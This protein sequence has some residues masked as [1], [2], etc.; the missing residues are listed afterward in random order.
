MS[1][2][3]FLFQGLDDPS[4]PTPSGEM[5][6]HAVSRGRTIRRRRHAVTLVA[7][8]GVLAAGVLA[9]GVLAA[10]A[11]NAQ[12]GI[13]GQHDNLVP[14]NSGSPTPGQSAGAT[15]HH[16]HLAG[17]PT[18]NAG[19]YPGAGGHHPGKPV[20]N[21]CP[22][23]TPSPSGSA[24]PAD[25]ASPSPTDSPAAAASPTTDASVAPTATATASPTA[26]TSPSASAAPTETPSAQ[27]SDT[28]TASPS[29]A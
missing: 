15:K 18:I 24:S 17:E 29:A 14:A 25:S 11:L 28:P 23:E 9:A 20:T 2:D 26:C 19:G 21:P 27:P 16:P 3:D 4:P 12:S 1:D 5:L 13:N 6:E 8:A 10:V 22:V 7:A